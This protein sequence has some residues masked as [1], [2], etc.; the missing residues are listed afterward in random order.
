MIKLLEGV[1]NVGEEVKCEECASVIHVDEYDWERVKYFYRG[2]MRENQSIDCP[3][4][5][6]SIYRWEDR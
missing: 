3:K 2:S 6:C 5:H 1:E 4:C